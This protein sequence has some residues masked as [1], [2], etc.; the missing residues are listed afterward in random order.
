VR[1]GRELDFRLSH[2]GLLTDRVDRVAAFYERCLGMLAGAS[3]GA[4]DGTDAVYLRDRERGGFRIQVHGPPWFDEIERGLF[5][6]RGSCLDR[7]HF[8]VADVPHAYEYLRASGCGSRLV[9]TGASQGWEAALY[10]P[11]GIEIWLRQAGEQGAMPCVA[12]MPDAGA[13]LRSDLVAELHHV[14]ILTPDRQTAVDFYTRVMGLEICRRF[15]SPGVVDVTFLADKAGRA[16]FLQI[17]GPPH[18]AY[19][20]HYLEEHGPGVNHLHFLVADIQVAQAC[21]LANG[22]QE[23][24]VPYTVDSVQAALVFDPFGIDLQ[25][26]DTP[27]ASLLL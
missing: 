25:F 14:G 19:E 9:P 23:N 7:L 12:P 27:P 1:G 3:P 8:S 21:L 2:V 15:Y 17:E 4:P 26:T 22:A 13:E 11:Q 6:G 18:L 24:I 20:E 5:E 10:D 16:A